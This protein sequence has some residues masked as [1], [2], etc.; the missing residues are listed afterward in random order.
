M[1]IHV[2]MFKQLC[3]V[4]G[5][6]TSM[7][8]IVGLIHIDRKRVWGAMEACAPLEVLAFDVE[9]AA[10]VDCGLRTG[11][12]C[13]CID[14]SNNCF[15]KDRVPAGSWKPGQRTPLCA[16]CDNQWGECR[17]CRGV[18]SC[19]PPEWSGAWPPDFTKPRPSVPAASSGCASSFVSVAGLHD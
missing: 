11:R 12:F 17:Y 15:A 2:F 6:A 16:R 9:P 14:G 3:A 19:T 18:H 10:C 8:Q 4:N 1:C 5:I 13:D 7:A